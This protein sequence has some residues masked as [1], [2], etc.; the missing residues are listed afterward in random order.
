MK[1]IWIRLISLVLALMM[2]S[3]VLLSCAEK[4]DDPK[5][6][7]G[8][9]PNIEEDPSTED[10]P[11]N[12]PDN[13]AAADYNEAE[14]NI[15][16]YSDSQVGCFYVPDKTGDLIDDAVWNARAAVEERFNVNIAANKSG[17]ESEP[18]H[19]ALINNQMTAG[20][21]DFD[22][23]NV[24]DVLGGNLSIQGVLVNILDIPQ[25]D[26]SK[27]WWSQKGV[28]SMSYMGQLYL[29]SSSI[30]YN[31]MASSQV[32]FF[33]KQMMDDRGMEYPY[34]DVLDMNWYLEDMF[35][36]IENVYQDNNDNGKDVEDIYGL[37]MPQEMYAIFESYGINMIEKSADGT[38]LILNANNE[39]VYDLIDA[40]YGIRYDLDGG[41]TD[42]RNTTADMFEASQGVYLTISL[43]YAVSNF[44]D[45]TFQYGIVPYPMLDE[46]QG[47]YYSGYTDRF[48][49]IPHTCADTNYVGTILEALSAEGYRQV[50]PSY[51]ETAL[52]GR[53][54]H[55]NESVQMLEIIR[56]SRV[57]D[58]AYIYSNDTACTRALYSLLKDKNHD[59]ASFYASKAPAAES[60]IEELTAYFTQMAD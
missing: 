27:P 31:S 37:L 49:V 42:V 52:K 46:A 3:M 18:A 7:P 54:T 6:D 39:R 1:K 60:R 36:S 41:Y 4:T 50:L 29:L 11:Y 9:D 14:F 56:E 44:R 33:N 24:H 32:V 30:S 12:V 16:Y 53:Y 57:I 15:L 59:Y 58:F 10:D 43:G 34:Q 25:F 19:I 17:A 23:A 13:L 8:D 22:V 28:E 5:N 26:F 35:T 55:D 51:Y 40:Y 38:E 2:M 47:D 20:A 45:A 48:M 21:T